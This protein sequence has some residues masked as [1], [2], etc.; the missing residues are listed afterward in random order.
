MS[1]DIWQE[2]RGV[3]ENVPSF[4][5][6]VSNIFLRVANQRLRLTAS[7][8]LSLLA[9]TS[10]TMNMFRWYIKSSANGEDIPTRNTK[11]AMKVDGFE[12]FIVIR[13]NKKT[14]GLAH[15]TPRT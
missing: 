13:I 9:D 7:K 11:E 3:V 6:E 12:K 15:C 5:M 4:V 1:T 2:D 10:S 8:L 14:D